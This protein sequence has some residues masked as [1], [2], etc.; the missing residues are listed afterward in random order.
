MLANSPALTR[1]VNSYLRP[2]ALPSSLSALSP[3]APSLPRSLAPSSP[4]PPPLTLPFLP[5]PAFPHCLT[6]SRLL[7]PARPPGPAHRVG[8][9]ASERDDSDRLGSTRLDS[10]LRETR[11]DRDRSP[12]A[13]SQTRIRGLAQTDRARARG[14]GPPPHPEIG[15][16]VRHKPPILLGRRFCGIGVL[17][18]VKPGSAVERRRRL[19][20]VA[21][22]A[23]GEAAGRPGPG[24]LAWAEFPVCRR[25]P[26]ATSRGGRRARTRAG[27]AAGVPRPRRPAGL[28]G[29]GR[30][31][32]ARPG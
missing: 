19:R 3:L 20:G 12:R 14:H 8:L 30:D 5:S 31:A 4:S 32:G 17:L 24:G 16:G 29:L 6:A 23:A 22:R 10:R 28:G 21:P 11:A 27:A 1:S 25:G 26:P 15:A 2:P 13:E 18:R 9:S 7:P